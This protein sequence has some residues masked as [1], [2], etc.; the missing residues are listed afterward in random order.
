MNNYFLVK[1]LHLKLIKV[2]KYAIDHQEIIIF[3]NSKC[4]LFS[5]GK[6]EIHVHNIF[7]FQQNAVTVFCYLTKQ[8]SQN[9][10]IIFQAMSLPLQPSTLSLILLLVPFSHNFLSKPH[11]KAA[12]I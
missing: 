11:G 5:W 4:Y 6:K 9:K 1:Q 8:I 7:Q 12:G 2:K 3:I 10:K